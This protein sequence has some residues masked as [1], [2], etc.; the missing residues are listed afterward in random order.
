MA[1]IVDWA[2]SKALD[3]G[4]EVARRHL[5]TYGKVASS[6]GEFEQAI[7][8]HQNEVQRW[9]EQINFSDLTSPKDTY[10]VYVNLNVFLIPKSLQVNCDE[11]LQAAPLNEILNQSNEHLVLTGHPG[12]GKTTSM[13]YICHRMVTEE[14]FLPELK[15]PLV[16]RLRDAYI[17][18]SQ[19]HQTDSVILSRIW[20]IFN[21][22][23]KL[24]NHR[25][26]G[27]S[28]VAEP[29][30]EE[31]ILL[32]FLEE[33]SPLII[34]DGFDE[35]TSHKKREVAINEIRTI[36][37]QLRKAR[38]ILT[39]RTGE[40]PYKIDNAKT[41]EISPLSQCQIEEFANKWLEDKNESDNFCAKIAESP[42][43]DTT[44]R[45]LTLAHLCALYIRI[46]D[47]P[48]KP[49]TV[50]RKI[51]QLLLEE[52]DEQ[53]SVKRETKHV[54]FTTDRKFDFLTELAFELTVHSSGSTFSKGKLKRTY[55]KICENY[56]LT[57]KGVKD[58]FG[59]GRV[60]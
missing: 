28:N 53:R 3:A 34:I 19:S 48:P 56:D 18:S 57:S 45:P 49:K 38:V 37:R 21:L 42:Y 4:F 52:W 47:I 55:R 26:T 5:A 12:A 11:S 15:F 32:G 6:K 39:S 9:F 25:K 8:T 30:L 10:R 1:M 2:I 50:Y 20:D 14:K 59:E 40:F 44:I 24:T 33:L 23:L 31:D 22:S 60:H 35:L 43:A 51:V 54:D 13:K 7:S 41:F 27:D 46:N 36:T 16:V 17:R 29:I 58:V